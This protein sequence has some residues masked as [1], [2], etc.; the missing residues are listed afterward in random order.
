MGR[1]DQDWSCD[2]CGNEFATSIRV[3]RRETKAPESRVTGSVYSNSS[4]SVE[5]GRA[6]IRPVVCG[7][8]SS[9][10]GD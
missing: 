4:V 1:I 2:H 6:T 9:A 8:R 10:D 3:H 7:R 5:N